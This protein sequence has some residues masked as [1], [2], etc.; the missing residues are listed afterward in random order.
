MVALPDIILPQISPQVHIQA[1]TSYGGVKRNLTAILP[2]SPP[3]PGRQRKRERTE[4]TASQ[5][6]IRG[7][8]RIMRGIKTDRDRKGDVSS[9][10]CVCAR[11]SVS[12][13]VIII[14]AIAK[15]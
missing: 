5:Q 4:Q 10:V 9:D 6:M 11:T 1:I 8:E 7:P 3:S 14:T 12:Q 15:A 13:K 2:I